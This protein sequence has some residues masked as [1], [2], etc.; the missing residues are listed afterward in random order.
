MPY[1]LT[2]QAISLQLIRRGGMPLCWSRVSRFP[3]E[4]IFRA[5]FFC[6]HSTAG[7]NFILDFIRDYRDPSQINGCNLLLKQWICA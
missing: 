1:G 3:L 6:T 7:G 5:M 4:F 2:P